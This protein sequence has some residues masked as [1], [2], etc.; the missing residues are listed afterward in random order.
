MESKVLKT[1]YEDEYSSS[2]KSPEHSLSSESAEHSFVLPSSVK[3]IITK[4]ESN[5]GKI[6]LIV[7]GYGFQ[8]KSFNRKKTVKFWR[9]TNR[10]CNVI[11]H[12]NVDDDFIQF[13]T[14]A[15]DHSHLPRP[16]DY[17]VRDLKKTM[18]KR[19]ATELVSVREIAEQ[20]MR[21]A[22]LT[23][24]ALATLSGTTTIGH[25][26]KH[27]RRKIIPPIP[28]STS[29]FIPD[30]YKRGYNNIERFLL[31]DTDDPTYEIDEIGTS[32]SRENF[33]LGI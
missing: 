13:S 33:N 32:I 31:H 11:L 2:S 3:P 17:E 10:N 12:T 15:I 5:K 26:L 24:E 30:M 8:F 23:G 18:R 28:K 14:T 25:G 20:E 21:N 4:T 16:A 22:L 6:M 9:C 29:F 7:D 19:A 27:H 1:I